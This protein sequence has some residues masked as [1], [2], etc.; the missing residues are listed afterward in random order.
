M[1][2]KTVV[3]AEDNQN[4][5]DLKIMALSEHKLAN[6]IE[7]ARDGLGDQEYL[8]SPGRFNERKTGNPA[9]IILDLKRMDG[10]GVLNEIKNDTLLKLISVVMGTS[11]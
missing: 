8:R 10:I 9:A 3:L 1:K 6:N 5:V 7:V 11:F 4:E 2:V